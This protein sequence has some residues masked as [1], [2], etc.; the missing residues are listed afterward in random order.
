MPSLDQPNN[1]HSPK[2]NRLF[3]A[4]QKLTNS[5]HKRVILVGGILFGLGALLIAG[6]YV[7]LA[8]ASIRYRLQPPPSAE[9]HIV[10]RNSAQLDPKKE[11]VIANDAEFG[12][13]IPKIHANASVIAHVNPFDA[14]VYQEALTRGVAHAE[15]TAVPAEAG[16]MFLFAHSAGDL[17]RARQ[18]N[19]VFYLLN[20]LAT[21]DDV[22]IFY[23]GEKYRYKVTKT[24]VVDP[25]RVEFLNN[26]TTKRSLILMTCTPAGTTRQRLLVHAEMVPSHGQ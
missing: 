7:P 20:K 23:Q 5:R 26:D 25:E 1:H 9:A 6:T 19:A 16:T 21:N 17:L 8:M 4:A 10:A 3:S 11:Y 12:I 13:V 18:Y 24:E 14:T 22:Y 15:G 2:S